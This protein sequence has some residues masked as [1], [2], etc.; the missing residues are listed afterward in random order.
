MHACSSQC[1]PSSYCTRGP[2]AGPN[3]FQTNC[4][5]PNLT[6]VPGV[7]SA[8]MT[9]IHGRLQYQ[10]CMLVVWPG[11]RLMACAT[12]LCLAHTWRSL[13]TAVTGVRLPVLAWALAWPSSGSCKSPSAELYVICMKEAVCHIVGLTILNSLSTWNAWRAQTPQ[14]RPTDVHATSFPALPVKQA[15]LSKC[16]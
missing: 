5:C 8:L 11:G 15:Q 13:H 6:N 1:C 12:T 16:I 14:V 7:E 9:R 3:S 4:S 10:S 2:S